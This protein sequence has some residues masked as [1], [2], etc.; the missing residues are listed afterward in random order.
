MLHLYPQRNPR[1]ATRTV[2]GLAVAISSDDSMLHDFNG[3]GTY[4]W[5]RCNGK[6]SVEE[7]IERF[8]EDYEVSKEQA[9]ADALEF[10][11]GCQ[12]K[13]LLFLNEEAIK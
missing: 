2:E 11:T 1:V 13:N 12:E 5:E 3:S 6:Q 9:E 7:L 4:L 10:L 8:R